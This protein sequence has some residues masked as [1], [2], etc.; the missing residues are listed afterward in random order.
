LL[1]EH[2]SKGKKAISTCSSK[3]VLSHR[4]R[5]IYSRLLRRLS[6]PKSEELTGGW[7][8]LHNEELHNLYSSP[9][10]IRIIRWR[11]MSSCMDGSNSYKTVVRK[12]DKKSYA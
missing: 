10:V 11:R 3:L 5:N 9:D 6:E 12:P 7:R 4:E 1:V 8:K 2:N